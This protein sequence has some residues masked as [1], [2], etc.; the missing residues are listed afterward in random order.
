MKLLRLLILLANLKRYDIR[1]GVSGTKAKTGEKSSIICR[2]R[3][4]GGTAIL[5]KDN[6][7]LTLI[8]LHRITSNLIQANV[9][10]RLNR[11]IRIW[12]LVLILLREYA[13][14]LR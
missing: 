14:N 13:Y 2:S 10:N 3:I 8:Q 11:K 7:W 5:F 4:R 6:D 12:T 1:A 9:Y